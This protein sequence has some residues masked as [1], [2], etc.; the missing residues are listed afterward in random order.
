MERS[1]LTLLSQSP[2]IGDCNKSIGHIHLSGK[3]LFTVYKRLRNG[4]HAERLGNYLKF[5]W[6]FCLFW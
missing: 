3:A 2:L 6:A 1:V 4:S 5:L